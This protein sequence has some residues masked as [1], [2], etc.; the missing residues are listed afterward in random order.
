MVLVSVQVLGV[1]RGSSLGADI[2]GSHLCH[3]SL[4]QAT[5]HCYF[6]YFPAAGYVRKLGAGAVVLHYRADGRS[7]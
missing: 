5:A 6:A 3:F 4:G 7:L 2:P 1:G